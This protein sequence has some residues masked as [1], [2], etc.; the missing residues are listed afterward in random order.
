LGKIYIEGGDVVEKVIEYVRETN[1]DQGSHTQTFKE[2]LTLPQ[3]KKA[4]WVGF[5]L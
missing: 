5:F 4:T 3:Y 2:A 1:Q